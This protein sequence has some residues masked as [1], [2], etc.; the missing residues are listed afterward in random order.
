MPGGDGRLR[1]VMVGEERSLT[2]S[3]KRLR[4]LASGPSRLFVP[5]SQTASRL[6]VNQCQTWRLDSP[7][8]VGSAIRAVQNGDRTYL[9]AMKLFTRKLVS[10]GY[11]RAVRM[12]SP[13]ISTAQCIQCL[14]STEYRYSTVSMDASLLSRFLGFLAIQNLG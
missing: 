7:F 5:S 9:I 11:I 12:N 8:A 10:A 3:S 6:M 13:L 14:S 1:V 4:L 2:M